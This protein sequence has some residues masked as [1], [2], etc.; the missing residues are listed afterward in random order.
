MEKTEGENRA[1]KITSSDNTLSGTTKC[2]RRRN[3][4]DFDAGTYGFSYKVLNNETFISKG[5]K[6]VWCSKSK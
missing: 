3:A 6:Y 1:S 4:G 2:V 5:K